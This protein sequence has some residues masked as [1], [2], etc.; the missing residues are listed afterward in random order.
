MADEQVVVFHLGKEEYCIP[1]HQVR[2]I[3]LYKGATMLPGTP[4]HFE[5]I[6]NLRG[7]IIPVIDLAVKFGVEG[8]GGERQALIVDLGETHFGIV[9][10]QV[11][12]VLHLQDSDV[13][14][15]PA[16]VAGGGAFIRGIGKTEG[17][18]LILLELANLLDESELSA[19][20]TAS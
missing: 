3:I 19:M 1:I 16:Q 7:R 8:K 15:A 10:D 6:I 12:E 9:V 5:G 14:A 13:E 11:S 20:E 4:K 17:R 18:L 2:E